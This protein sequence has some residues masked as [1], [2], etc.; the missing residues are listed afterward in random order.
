[1]YLT[2]SRRDL[3]A[4]FEVLIGSRRFTLHESVFTPRS[5][6]LAS[7]RRLA[8]IAS[9]RYTLKPVDLSD[10]DPD[11]FQTYMNCVYF[12]KAVLQ[13]RLGDL[14]RQIE[15]YGTRLLVSNV[16]PNA[17]TGSLRHALREIGDVEFVQILDDN[18]GFIN[19]SLAA[20]CTAANCNKDLKSQQIF[21]ESE[22]C[23][24]TA[25]INAG[26]TAH[27]L[28][29]ETYTELIRLYLLAEKLIDLRTANMT[30]DAL[31]SLLALCK[32]PPDHDS[33]KLIYTSTATKR[34][35]R[36]RV[37][38]RDAWVFHLS[39]GGEHLTAESGLTKTFV[40]DVMAELLK[41][42]SKHKNKGAQKKDARIFGTGRCGLYH[43][44]DDL[45]CKMEDC[46][47]AKTTFAN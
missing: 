21:L 5:Q 4:T 27:T 13:E 42:A 35:S 36:L 24:E 47:I 11:V 8:A 44:H 14:K 30:S 26:E 15:E 25:L 2:S 9:L 38:A 45:N 18:R 46:P 7:T 20:S 29:Q 3:T 32:I 12:G 31:I 37:F 22:I 23:F 10:E 40:R 39:R 43:L 33:L 16:R 41:P 17:T 6:L 19:F 28:A 1:M 34:D